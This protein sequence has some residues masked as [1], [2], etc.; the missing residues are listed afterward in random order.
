MIDNA[1]EID[2]VSKLY[3]LGEVG[4]GTLSRDLNRWWAKVRGKEDPYAKIGRANDRTQKSRPGD[5]V[6]A[7]RDIDFCVRQGETVGIVGKNGAG[8]STL[9]K[10][11]SRITA[12]TRGVIRLRGKVASLL[13]VGTGFHPEMTGRENVF[14]NGTLLG[15]TR[16]EIRA[17]L[18]DIVDFAGVASYIDTPVKRYS[19]GMQVRLA[20]AV[21]AFLEPDVLIVD[22]VLAVGDSEFQAKALSKIDSLGNSES[23][24][25]LIVSHNL[26]LIKKLCPR[27]IHIEQGMIQ[28]DGRT[29]IVIDEYL[30][31]SNVPEYLEGGIENDDVAV[32]RFS[33]TDDTGI[34]KANYSNLETIRICAD[35]RVKHDVNYG[36][37]NVDLVDHYG[38]IVLSSYHNDLSSFGGNDFFP[39]GKYR[40]VVEIPKNFL[41]KGRYFINFRF[42][43]HNE[44][45]IVSAERIATLD[46]QFVIPNPLFSANK[47]SSV[48]APM[49]GWEITE[50]PLQK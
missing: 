11:I 40:V 2:H 34:P 20:F 24:T 42:G 31:S 13:E 23:R 3:R 25:I 32:E 43:I 7:L 46:V 22:E 16:S 19:S 15:M 5:V 8:K 1:I 14:M 21:A 44:R 6:W 30:S 36:K 4:T 12:P 49:L 29:D 18:D 35:L 28:Q 41:N 39:M 10:I 50:K 48:T 38:N 17:K 27:T 45:W 33:L 37:F 26:A 47:R 9:L